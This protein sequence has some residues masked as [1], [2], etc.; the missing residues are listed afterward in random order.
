MGGGGGGAG[1]GGRW[2]GEQNLSFK[3]NPLCERRG[4]I[5]S[6]KSRPLCERIPIPVK[7]SIVLKNRHVYPQR[8]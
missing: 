4:Q 1:A 3:S 5:L 7:R 2:M 8:V 6:F